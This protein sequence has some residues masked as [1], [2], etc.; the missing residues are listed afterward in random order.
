MSSFQISPRARTELLEIEE[1][2][3]LR[4]GERQADAY[5][6]G[7]QKAFELIASFPGMGRSADELARGYRRYRFQKH[8]IFY[9]DEG[10]HILVRSV[11]HTSRDL[12]ADLFD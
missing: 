2:T 8:Y 5:I 10:D 6:T 9:T 3:A 7:L 1:F 4:W 11:V 12:R